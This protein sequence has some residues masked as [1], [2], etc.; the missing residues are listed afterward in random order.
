MNNTINYFGSCPRLE[1][2]KSKYR[3]L[4]LLYHPDRGG[5]LAIMQAINAQYHELLKGKHNTK[6]FNDDNKE[7]TYQYNENL[8]QIIIDMISKVLSE[9]LGDDVNLLLIGTWLWIVGNT[10][11]VKDKI[12]ALGFKWHSKKLCWFFHSGQW[13][14]RG[15]NKSLSDIAQAYGYKKY[16]SALQTKLGA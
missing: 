5:D 14:G 2:I 7:Y 12:K 6:T 3:E 16:S 13:K 1:D 8:E 4:A 11:P 15:S 9:K 10:K